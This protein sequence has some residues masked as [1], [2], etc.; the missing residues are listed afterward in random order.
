MNNRMSIP[1]A[2]LMLLSVGVNQ[3]SAQLTDNKDEPKKSPT[4]F[5]LWEEENWYLLAD[6]PGLHIAKAREAFLMLDPREAAKQLRKA[7]VHM[8]IAAVDASDRTRGRLKHAQHDLEKT[9]DRVEAGTLKNIEEFDLATARA[10]HAMSEYQYIKAA[11]AWEKKEVRQAGHYLRAAADNVERAAAKTEQRFR[12]T[13]SE[14][15]HESRELSGS[16]IRGTGYV[17]D[18]VGTG[19]ERIGHQIELVGARVINP[20]TR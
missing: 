16:L 1:F 18:E 6:E 7:A 19:F 15:A 9:A 2:L 12:A 4:V 11:I 17:I 13:T 3:A 14:V 5:S 20:I 10:M 8:Q